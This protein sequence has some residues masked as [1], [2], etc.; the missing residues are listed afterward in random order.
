MYTFQNLNDSTTSLKSFSSPI[1]SGSDSCMSLR[2]TP[3]NSFSKAFIVTTAIVIGFVA[4]NVADVACLT[5]LPFGKIP[6][7]S[8][9]NPSPWIPSEVLS[10]LNSNASDTAVDMDNLK[11]LITSVFGDVSVSTEIYHDPDE[12]WS[13][14]LVKIDSNLGDDFDKQIRLEDQLFANIWNSA[15]LKTLSQS[16][17]ITQT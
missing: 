2:A 16:L 10:W 5:K 4:Q 8:I 15:S 6:S 13:K 17:I 7:L 1:A 12:S 14:V 3:P 9:S 11:S